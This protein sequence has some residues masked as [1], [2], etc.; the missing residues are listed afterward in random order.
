MAARRDTEESRSIEAARAALTT[1]LPEIEER[2]HDVVDLEDGR[3]ETSQIT[4]PPA[5]AARADRLA[6][7]GIKV[8]GVIFRKPTH[9]LT[10]QQPYQRKPEAWIDAYEGTYNAG[11]GVDQI[12]WRMPPSFPTVFLAGCNFTFRSL[13]SG[14]A[15]LSLDFEA[16]PYQGKTGTVV[17]E[18]GAQRTEIPIST[19]A[20]RTVDIGFTHG[21]ADTL[22]TM[23]F[24]RPGLIDFVFR[25]VSL[26]S[27][28]IVFE[29]AR[30][31]R[32]DAAGRSSRPGRERRR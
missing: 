12:W 13:Q 30:T 2:L 7:F 11:P 1:S 14:P 31:G 9:R 5:A 23:V 19:P 21:G 15:L 4:R 18:I 20:A 29:P 25:S 22:V 3:I 17:I 28:P 26:G 8:P 10:P 27:G 6:E 32:A 16:W 24:F